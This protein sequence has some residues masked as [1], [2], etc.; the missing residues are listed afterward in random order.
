MT[1][2]HHRHHPL[3]KQIVIVGQGP[4]ATENMRTALEHRATK[5]TFL[6]RRHGIV[7]PELLDA[8]N[9][10]RP[11]D[12]QLSRPGKG[13][14]TFASAWRRA[15]QASTATPPE[16]WAQGGFMPD[17]HGVSVSDIYFVAHFCQRVNSIVGV[18]TGFEK[19]A[20]LV[21]KDG[22]KLEADVLIRSI[23]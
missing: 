14:A 13:S 22:T 7:C 12:D 17:G 11:Y 10:I 9:Y 20:V 5:I 21:N 23:G 8:L 4:Y 1:F 2:A 15:Y 3:A 19:L 18:A 16:C 6:C